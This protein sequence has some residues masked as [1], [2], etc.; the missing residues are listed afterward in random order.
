MRSKNT[1]TR[2][3]VNLMQ[4]NDTQAIFSA[5]RTANLR[6][7]ITHES[8]TVGFPSG[9]HQCCVRTSNNTISPLV[10]ININKRHETM[11]P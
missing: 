10:N 7:H 1:T 6:R 2:L 8:E 5:S 11:T 9:Q 4:Q 3:L